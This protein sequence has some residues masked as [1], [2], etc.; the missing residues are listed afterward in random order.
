MK[1]VQGIMFENLTDTAEQ[2]S[3]AIALK[4]LEHISKILFLWYLILI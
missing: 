4:N 2:H 1:D 3:E